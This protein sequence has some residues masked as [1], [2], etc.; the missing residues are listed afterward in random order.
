MIMNLCNLI[1]GIDNGISEG[2]S[3]TNPHKLVSLP[4]YI[5]LWANNK[6]LRAEN[7]YSEAQV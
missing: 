5:H 7:E 1:C 6:E 4:V 3:I 2:S